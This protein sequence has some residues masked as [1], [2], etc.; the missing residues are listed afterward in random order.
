MAPSQAQHRRTHNLLL[1]NNLLTQA[2]SASPFTLV[3]DS[4]EQSGKPV[5]QEVIA[6][7]TVSVSSRLDSDRMLSAVQNAKLS[8]VFISFE[9]LLAP[10]GVDTFIKTWEDPRWQSHAAAIGGRSSQ[11]AGKRE[12]LHTG[13]TDLTDHTIGC[14]LII[15]SLNKICSTKPDEATALLS[16]LISPSVSLVAL[17]HTDVVARPST[18]Q[19]APAALDLLS[20]LATT[21]FTIHSLHH[22]L[23]RKAARDRSV[24]EP[25][26]G[27]AEGE[28]GIVQG[29]NA[30][31]GVHIVLEMEH[32][33]KSGRGVKEL[34]VLDTRRGTKT[35]SRLALL[36]EYPGYH[37]KADVGESDVAKMRST[38]ELGL[39]EQQ[40]RDRDGVVLPYTDAQEG[41]VEGGRILY[42]MGSEDD[43]DEEED[44]I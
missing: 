34:Y 11:E 31:T 42:D 44:E 35:S 17:H 41:N 40:R 3:L 7:A 12:S 14:L 6:N 22:V 9:T 37:A 8:V 29:L 27:L 32:R 28:P 4:L 38:F 15:D 10:A 26:F 39:T 1:V 19:Y 13:S 18:N 5:L 2:G 23:A 30:N 16:S 43:F 36:D 25:D 21:I 24:V 20:Y 33:R